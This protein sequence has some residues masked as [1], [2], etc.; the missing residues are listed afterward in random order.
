[1]NRVP[2]PTAH[3]AIRPLASATAGLDVADGIMVLAVLVWAGNNV[4]VTWALGDIDPVAYVPGRFILV[5]PLLF[6]WLWLRGTSLRVRRED[7]PLVVLSAVTGFA[8]YNL[9]VTIGQ[10][11]TTAS[12]VTLLL[13]LGP[14]FTMVLAAAPRIERMRPA[15]WVCVVLAVAGIGLFVWDKLAN[16]LPATGD[17]L[18]L[19][20]AMAWA[21][22]SLSA[23]RL[24]GRY[25]ATT[26][27]ARASLMG[28]AAVLPLAPRPALKRDWIGIGLTGWGAMLYPSALSMLAGYSLWSWAIA[29]RGI[30]RTAPYRWPLRGRGGRRSRGRSTRP[31]DGR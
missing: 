20:S 7:A 18:S 8:L 27:T 15:Q 22:Y 31:R 14:V 16:D 9:L 10:A 1:M 26:V 28:A 6:P 11:H 21:V 13:S 17:L 3:A 19:I 25:P 24:S 4:I 2:T 29:R 12:S 23:R 30:G 5:A